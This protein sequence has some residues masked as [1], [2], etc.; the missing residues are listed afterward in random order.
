VR[1]CS[2]DLDDDLDSPS[3][4]NRLL[5]ARVLDAVPARGY[6]M[7]ALLSLLRIEVTRAVPT[8]AVSCQRRP[9]L[10]IN[11]D[12]VEAHCQ[13]DEHLFLLVM[14][15]LHHV[16][17]GHTRLFP[18]L[19]PLHNL[20]FDAVINAL[21]CLRFPEAAYTSFFSGLYGASSG[22]PRL[23]APPSPVL[24]G[25]AT[26]DALHQS[27]YANGGITAEEIFETI[28]R[29]APP[30]PPDLLLLG[31]HGEDVDAWGTD[32][33]AASDVVVAIREIVERWPKPRDVRLGRSLS[34]LMDARTIETL[35]PE[36]AVRAVVRRALCAAATRPG[37]PRVRTEATVDAQVVLPTLQDRR[38]TVAR[39]LAR[40]PLLYRRSLPNPRGKAGRR[41]AVYLDVSGSMD[42]YLAPL[43]G[44][45][46]ALRTHV[47]SEV[48]LFSTVVRTVPLGALCRGRVESTG[49]TDIGCVLEHALT[50]DAPR[51]LVVTDGYVG[52]PHESLGRRYRTRGPELRVLLTPGGW[53]S[54]LA[55]LAARID[56]LPTL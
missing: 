18:R 52:S 55:P 45:L 36:R 5:V 25:D 46:R 6:E 37:G 13:S 56:V 8:A 16:L 31:S 20:A 49:G 41:A 43:Y 14:H 11:P 34:D 17:L 40:N 26:L 4:A 33:A 12:F 47:A 19:T 29:V 42:A 38:A 28:Q 39:A 9:V 30:P 50:I 54:D 24:T 3:A 27:I 53:R 1:T 10:R 23:L 22:S 21:L 32:S 2:F 44:A 15:E 51:V 35:T 7:T 48:H